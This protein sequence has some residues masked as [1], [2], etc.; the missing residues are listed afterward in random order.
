MSEAKPLLYSRSIFI[1]FSV[2]CLWN[3]LN[4]LLAC[5]FLIDLKTFL[6]IRKV[7]LCNINDKQLFFKQSKKKYKKCSVKQG[8]QRLM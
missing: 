1:S 2:N 5:Y 3:L 6:L 7:A 8:M 4:F